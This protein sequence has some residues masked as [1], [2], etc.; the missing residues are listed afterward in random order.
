MEETMFIRFLE[1][2][3]VVLSAIVFAVLP[4]ILT[5]C[6][7]T[8]SKS[9]S[10][11]LS[12][13]WQFTLLQNYPVPATQLSVSGF[14]TETNNALT[15]SFQVPVLGTSDNCGG[16]S[17]VSGTVSGSNVSLF[18]NNSGTTLNFTGTISPDGK[19]M[20]GDYQG[21][22]GACFVNV[23]TGTWNALLIPPLNGNFTG[24]LTGSAYMQALTGT[25]APPPISVSGSFTQ[26]PN[27]GASNAALTGTITAVGY[28]C[29][30]TAALTGTISG[31]NVY[32]S[33]FGYNGVQIGTLGIP[34]TQGV[35]GA[36][37]IVVA[38]SSSVSLTGTGG[39]G[40]TLG[41]T[42]VASCP[43][44]SGVSGDTTTVDVT[45]Q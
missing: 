16:V 44:I 18:V 7:S 45:L 2:S 38:T 14:M 13:N 20:S 21:L 17:T 15:G 19:S 27:A 39:S 12:G 26:G 24:T 28:P 30:T 25:T 42:G 3:T 33:V 9:T 29:F 35:A 22:A 32:L 41:D 34:G 31:Q 4:L 8:S 10:G 23:S 1:R 36:P 5:S 6:G 11:A 40:L 37:A 43:P